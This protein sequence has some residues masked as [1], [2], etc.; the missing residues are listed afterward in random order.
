MGVCILVGAG[1]FYLERSIK[2]PADTSAE[3]VP[4]YQEVPENIGVLFQ[5]LNNKTFVYFNFDREETA[6]VFAD[7]LEE[8]ESFYGYEI[9]HRI[10]M[11]CDTL[12]GIVDILGGIDLE[13]EGQILN[14]TGTQI[15][16]LLKT[17]KS[18]LDLRREII[19]QVFEK[20]SSKGFS[21]EDVLYVI[22]NSETDLSV[23]QCFAFTDYLPEAVR[24]Y[25]FV[26]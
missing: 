21:L 17:T 19:A 7:D 4:Y 8:A 16:H 6:V 18:T 22:E 10:E 20:I 13:T 3:K 2:T 24:N 11:D 12:G 1:Y 26:N 5:V 25:Y 9:T 23:P 15:S 14:F